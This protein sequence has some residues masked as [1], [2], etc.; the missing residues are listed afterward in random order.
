MCCYFDMIRDLKDNKLEYIKNLYAR[1]FSDLN[2]IEFSTEKPGMQIGSDEGKLLFLLIKM[3]G[4]K[5]ILELGTFLGYSTIWMAKALPNDGKITT[6]EKNKDYIA[7]AKENFKNCDVGDKI[8]ILHGD[9]IDILP[10]LHGKSFDMIFIDANKSKY[11]SY[12]DFAEKFLKKNG[13]LVADNTLLFDT[14]YNDKITSFNKKIVA[15]MREFNIR[16]ADKEKFCSILL[17]TQ[18]GFTIVLKAF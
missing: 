16:L 8:D 11:L 3:K 6:V 12:L 17:P 5:K 2:Q 10:T 15:D 1:D 14:V 9:A 13:L 7:K 18:S 4:V